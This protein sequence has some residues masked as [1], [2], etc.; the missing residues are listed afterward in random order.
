MDNQTYTTP[1]KAFANIDSD[2][3]LC[4][5]DDILVDSDRAVECDIFR[6]LINREFNLSYPKHFYA[7]L[8]QLN[9]VEFSWF[10]SRNLFGVNE[11]EFGSLREYIDKYCRKEAARAENLDRL[12]K[13]VCVTDQAGLAAI[14]A[15]QSGM[16]RTM[17]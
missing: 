8:A 13:V 17:H 11:L 6:Q 3:I 5:I 16:S 7:S 15:W 12:M 2:E 10:R 14:D 1:E 9:I 4:M